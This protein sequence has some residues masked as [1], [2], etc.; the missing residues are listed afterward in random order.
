MVN[1]AEYIVLSVKEIKVIIQAQRLVQSF[2]KFTKRRSHTFSQDCSQYIPTLHHTFISTI[3]NLTPSSY[4][5][6]VWWCA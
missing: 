1:Y 5:I 3:W 4:I 6:M 2:Y